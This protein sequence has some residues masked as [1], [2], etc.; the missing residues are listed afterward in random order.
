[1]RP[2]VV[3][4]WHLRAGPGYE[5]LVQND[6]VAWKWGGILASGGAAGYINKGGDWVWD[7]DPGGPDR[8]S[9]SAC[10]SILEQ[11]VLT[12]LDFA[13]VGERLGFADCP[14]VAT[15]SVKLPLWSLFC[16]SRPSPILILEH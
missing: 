15:V 8:A 11:R 12:I 4:A 16:G 9:I 13:L 6:R 10:G 2:I 14:N 3:P 7:W 1:M 5:G